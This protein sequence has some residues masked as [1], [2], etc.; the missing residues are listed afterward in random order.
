MK[1]LRRTTDDIIEI[2][3]GN[4]TLDFDPHHKGPDNE[5][6]DINSCLHDY[7][8]RMKIIIKDV[9]STSNN[10][11]THARNFDDLATGMNE[12]TTTEKE[13]LER[14]STEMQAI[15]ESI[16]QLSAESETLSKI[17]EET[18]ASIEAARASEA[19]RG[20]K[21]HPL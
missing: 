10:L 1:K 3:Q 4:L 11:Q 6:T 13:S 14:L 18:A 17:A 16:Q 2:S 20:Y 9:N 7:L 12:S 21:D 15:N 5:I 8:D 19:G